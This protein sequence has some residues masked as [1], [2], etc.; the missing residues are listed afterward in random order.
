VTATGTYSATA[1]LSGSA[2]WVMQVAAFR[3]NSG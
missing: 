1:A 2:A 3:A